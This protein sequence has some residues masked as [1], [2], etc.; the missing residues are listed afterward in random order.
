MMQLRGEDISKL[1][2]RNL[3]PDELKDQIK[4]SRQKTT[5]RTILKT[6]VS[7]PVDKEVFEAEQEDIRERNGR[8]YYVVSK[9]RMESLW[10]VARLCPVFIRGVNFFNQAIIQKDIEKFDSLDQFYQEEM[11]KVVEI[12]IKTIFKK[13]EPM[14]N[15]IIKE[16]LSMKLTPAAIK[17]DEAQRKV[18][19][20]SIK[21][22]NLEPFE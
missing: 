3:N 6:D 13:M 5:H 16:G 19:I 12:S 21:F 18:L 8:K 9:K 14:L 17:N 7:H 1:R 10:K 2:H 11:G 15:K 20:V 22:L 4:T